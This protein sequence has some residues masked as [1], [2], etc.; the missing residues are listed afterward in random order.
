MSIQ[1]QPVEPPDGA[2]VKQRYIPRKT[3]SWVEHCDKIMTT[4]GL[5]R[6]VETYPT[7]NAARHHAR[8]L[9]RLMRELRMHEE[10]QLREHVER[11]DRGWAWTVEYL[12]RQP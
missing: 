12:G 1:E 6:G 2:Y 11:V 9:K 7:Y 3:V 5:V 10:W 8:R 4:H